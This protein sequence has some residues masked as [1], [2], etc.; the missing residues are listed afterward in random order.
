MWWSGR[1][2][3]GA[4]A[5]PHRDGLPGL[6]VVPHLDVAGNV[7][8]GI[9]RKQRTTE[10]VEGP[11]T[12]GVSAGWARA[13][14]TL[15]GGQQQRVALARAIARNRPCSCST[16]LLEPRHGTASAGPLRIHQLLV[17]LGITTI[18]V[19]HDQEEAFLL[20]TRWLSCPT[21]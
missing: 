18:F 9:P 16:S 14:G 1:A 13:A 10:R 20:G 8:Y 4:R 5:P 2:A 3:C 21:A 11:S 12:G 7:G 6:G 17:E 19:T 15:S